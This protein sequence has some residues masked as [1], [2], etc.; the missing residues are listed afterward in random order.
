MPE[1]PFPIVNHCDV[2]LFQASGARVWP[3][4]ILIYCQMDPKHKLHSNSNSK[5]E[6]VYLREMYLRMLFAKCG[7]FWSSLNEL[8]STIRHEFHT[9]YLVLSNADRHWSHGFVSLLFQSEVLLYKFR[10]SV[11]EYYPYKTSCMIRHPN[12][13]RSL[14]G[15]WNTRLVTG[16]TLHPMH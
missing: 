8:N 14:C 2:K 5:I 1:V 16:L 12:I 9:I 3:E 6:I 11:A 10:D 7:P 4:P 13:T 15:L